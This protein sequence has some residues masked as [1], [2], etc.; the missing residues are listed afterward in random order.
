MLFFAQVDLNKTLGEL[1][2]DISFDTLL[3]SKKDY[4]VCKMIHYNYSAIWDK[5]I[6]SYQIELFGFHDLDHLRN[7]FLK[8]KLY[9][10]IHRYPDLPL[11]TYVQWCLCEIP[12]NEGDEKNSNLSLFDLLTALDLTT[13]IDLG[14]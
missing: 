12:H 3:L 11:R 5:R 4:H 7:T 1:Y 8:S 2:G 13:L 6:E 14:L 9:S 10:D